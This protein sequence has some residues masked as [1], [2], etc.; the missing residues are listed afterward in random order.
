MRSQTFTLQ[1]IKSA[2]RKTGFVPYNP[3][4]MVEKIKN[5]QPRSV[6]PPPAPIVLANPPYSTEDII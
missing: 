3:K 5:L 1:T 4:I 6:T 2:F